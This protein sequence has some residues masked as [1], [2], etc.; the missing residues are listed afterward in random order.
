MSPAYT[1]SSKNVSTTG[2]AGEFRKIRTGAQ[3][4][5]QLRRLPVRPKVWSGATD[6]R[7]VAEPSRKNTDTAI[8]TGLSGSAIHI[9]D[10]A[11]NSH[12]ETSSPRLTANETHTV[13]I[14]KQL[15]GTGNPRKGDPYSQVAAPPFTMVAERRQCTHRPA[16]TPNKTCSANVYRYIKRR[17]GRLNEHIARGTWSLP[18]S[19]LHIYY[20]EL[21]A[22]FLALKEFQDHCSDKIVLVAT[23]NTTVVSC[24]N[25]KGGMRSGPLFSST[26]E[27]LDLV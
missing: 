4:G 13:A 19:K 6:S 10:S 3:T 24:I 1:G 26:M 14:E 12:R 8:P 18:E 17:L 23:D 22:V 27:N 15:E 16:V 25:N 9:L 21:K 11:A 20:L 2:L 7:L 5:F